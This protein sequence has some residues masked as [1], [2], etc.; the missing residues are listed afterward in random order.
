MGVII[1]LLLKEEDKP[2]NFTSPLKETGS[3][4]EKI[5]LLKTSKIS[6][7]SKL[8]EIYERYLV[9]DV[10][11]ANGIKNSIIEKTKQLLSGG[12]KERRIAQELLEKIEDETHLKLMT[13]YD[14]AEQAIG[15]SDYDKAA[16]NFEKASEI[17]RELLEEELAKLLEERAK[18][19]KKIPALSKKRDKIAQDARYALKNEDFKS[20]CILYKD[21]S[22]L[23][24]EL[25]H[26]DKEEE[27]M[28]KSKALHDFYQID[29]RFKK[30]KE[31]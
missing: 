19:S 15:E 8:K 25:M 1:G 26:Y 23:S 14:N 30:K 18:L 13:Y 4:L 27:Y 10:I 5:D 22:D 16:K 29:E 9:S 7:Q 12:K 11:D 28:L 6:L 24:K 20:A 2:E 17:A 3:A 21:A 31:E